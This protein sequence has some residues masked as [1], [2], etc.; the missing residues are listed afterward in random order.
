MY[1]SLFDWGRIER[2]LPPWQWRFLQRQSR[3]WIELFSRLVAFEVYRPT[4]DGVLIRP[5]IIVN[6]GDA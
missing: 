3:A 2:D 1:A 5:C 4:F 6:G